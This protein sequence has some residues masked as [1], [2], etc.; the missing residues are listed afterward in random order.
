MRYYSALIA[1]IISVSTAQAWEANYP[2]GPVRQQAPQ[3]NIK[4]HI[5]K[6][7]PEMNVDHRL[8][9][10][11][12]L[13]RDE[14]FVRPVDKLS[15]VSK[16]QSD[17]LFATAFSR[18]TV[19][20]PI[21]DGVDLGHGWDFLSNQKEFISCVQFTKISDDKYQTVDSRIQ[22]T[23]DE[24]TLDISLNTSFSASASGTIEVVKASGEASFSLNAS[25]H[26]SSSDTSFIAH[27]SATNGVVYAG[28][29]AN[30][31]LL[32]PD[33]AQLAASDAPSF[34]AKCGDGF[35][36]SIG[37]GADLYVML[38]AHDLT[39]EDKVDLETSAKAS[40]GVADIFSAGAS[41]SFSA[42]IDDL[43]TKKE[44]DIE[45]V[46]QGGIFTTVPTNLAEAKTKVQ[47]FMGEEKQGPRSL[48]VT[49]VPYSDLPNWPGVYMLDTSDMR[50]RAIRYLQR[51]ETI[52]Y[53][54]RNMR[55][56][57]FRE[58]GVKGDK[59]LFDYAHQL[60]TE[61]LGA[62]SENVRAD[63]DVV[64]DLLKILDGPIC[65]HSPISAEHRN[66]KAESD[67]SQALKRLAST[68]SDCEE[69]VKVVLAQMEN[70]DDFRFWITLPLP[71]DGVSEKDRQII[72]DI[73]GGTT[74]S[75]R[76]KAFEQNL[77]R[78][79]IERT[80]QIR[81]RLF[82]E[83]LTKAEQSTQYQ[84]IVS[85]VEQPHPPFTGVTISLAQA[86]SGE[87]DYD[88][89]GGAPNGCRHGR[90]FSCDQTN[91]EADAHQ[92]CEV[93]QDSFRHSW[94]GYNSRDGNH[95]GYLDLTITCYNFSPQ[96][97]NGN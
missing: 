83:C 92:V 15:F 7:S 51:L 29:T 78:Y 52:L 41:G 12:V 17:P 31:L 74:L 82:F 25:H 94:S 13:K 20:Y 35:V 10:L 18:R 89:S 69:K 3:T 85:N 44:L 63:M 30:G 53:E 28:P 68:Q 14:S 56:N 26:M 54:I 27:E 23:I 95:C 90:R 77:Y 22:Q 34:R 88:P 49:L 61:D 9:D 6:S 16:L 79:W 11:K 57:Y 81:C 32:R 55:E 60:R 73:T 91:Y 97:P 39:T 66:G 19:A 42:K 86:C 96:F 76:Q 36:A 65:T 47:T 71:L 93:E 5:P 59:Y 38:H 75:A 40:A 62:T 4:I 50:Q 64:N 70:F 58:D 2:S 67:R 72:T 8:S 43:I 33:M 87:R 80:D 21:P 84:K 1:S 45:F 37:L 46:Q 24:E 48:F